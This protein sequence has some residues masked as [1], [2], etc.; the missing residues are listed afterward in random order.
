[1]IKE[2]DTWYYSTKIKNTSY[3]NSI[4]TYTV[5]ILGKGG[6][7]HENWEGY[8][9]V[10]RNINKAYEDNIVNGRKVQ[11]WFKKF[12]FGVFFTAK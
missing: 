8:Q 3:Y 10:A 4:Y 6:N 7:I 9:K 5:N 1:M 2:K 12:K 11:P